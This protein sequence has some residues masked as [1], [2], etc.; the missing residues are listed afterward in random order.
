MKILGIL[1]VGVLLAFAALG[2]A[3]FEATTGMYADFTGPQ[4]LHE[5]LMDAK[6]RERESR[7]RF[8]RNLIE[9][10]S[11]GSRFS[12]DKEEVECLL[13]E[14]EDQNRRLLDFADKFKR[15]QF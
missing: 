10:Q 8:Y 5:K 3:H 15:L 13:D 1:F 4:P 7:R 6:E 12:D 9:V 14:A 11:S 2:A